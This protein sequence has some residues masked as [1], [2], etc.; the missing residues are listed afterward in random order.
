MRN[1]HIFYRNYGKNISA[2]DDVK[3]I[4]EYR[5]EGPREVL[6]TPN[7]PY[8]ISM[9][10]VGRDL[11]A[12]QRRQG[13]E[14]IGPVLVHMGPAPAKPGPGLTHWRSSKAEKTH[15]QVKSEAQQTK[16]LALALDLNSL[17]EPSLQPATEEKQQQALSAREY[18]RPGIVRTQVPA[19]GG[20]APSSS[21]QRGAGAVFPVTARTDEE[22]GVGSWRIRMPEL[23]A[24]FN[25][26]AKG[27]VAGSAALHSPDTG[28]ASALPSSP[29]KK[30]ANRHPY[31]PRGQRSNSPIL[32]VD[33]YGNR[34]Q[35]YQDAAPL[36]PPTVLVPAVAPHPPAGGISSSS[37]TLKFTAG[38]RRVLRRVTA[39]EVEGREAAARD[40]AMRRAFDSH[41]AK[42]PLHFHSAAHHAKEVQAAQETHAKLM[43]LPIAEA[44]KAYSL[45]INSRV[46]LCL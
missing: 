2:A 8:G 37:H 29:I 46:P 32:Q 26:A 28:G 33:H 41:A 15:A 25:T 1:I 17:Q 10:P 11:H 7:T 6:V 21:N 4:I 45:E 31:P 9:L 3:G 40:L 39:L 34:Y 42:M 35:A 16:A 20:A 38:N 12:G 27:V 18:V 30:L 36:S 13:G 23:T 19:H 5:H 44:F 22:L 14:G 43:K 24:S